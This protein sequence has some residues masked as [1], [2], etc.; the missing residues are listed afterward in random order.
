MV[1]V[2]PQLHAWWHVF[3]S[4]GLYLLCVTV[5]H[6]RLRVLAKARAGGFEYEAK[7]EWVCAVLPVARIKSR[8]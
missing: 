8:S 4:C 6:S 2:N 7:I 3:V 5:T 1:P